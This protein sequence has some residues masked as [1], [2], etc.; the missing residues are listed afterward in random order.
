MNISQLINLLDRQIK[1]GDMTDQERKRQSD[2]AALNHFQ[3]D[4]KKKKSK[5]DK[6]E[7]ERPDSKMNPTQLRKKNDNKQIDDDDFEEGDD[8]M[9]L[10]QKQID[11]NLEDNESDSD[12]AEQ[13]TTQQSTGPDKN[14]NIKNKEFNLEYC[15]NYDKFVKIVNTFRST[16][17]IRNDRTVKKYWEKLTLAEKQAIYVFFDNLTHVSDAEK[18]EHFQMPD[19][20]SM[21][22]IHISPAGNQPKSTQTQQVDKQL[23]KKVKKAN[24]DIEK[25]DDKQ[26][27]IIPIT[28]GESRT[29]YISIDK[30]LK[31]VK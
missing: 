25:P 30:L 14:T 22:G 17:S 28:V 21:L 16:G 27:P 12:D 13:T 11:K 31:E 20:P 10:F 8:P 5:E 1:E 19:T 23:D 6:K 29:R 2:L 3:A 26:T 9:S 18:E 15:K 24:I 7:K 4:T